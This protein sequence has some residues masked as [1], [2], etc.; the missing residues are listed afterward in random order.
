MARLEQNMASR[1]KA[2]RGSGKSWVQSWHK[3]NLGVITASSC[4]GSH[5]HC[6]S[7][8]SSWRTFQA[9]VE[10]HSSQIGLG[11]GMCAVDSRPSLC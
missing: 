9:G 1:I 8:I 4:S 3:S 5:A 10:I 6:N 11:G 7:S 2:L